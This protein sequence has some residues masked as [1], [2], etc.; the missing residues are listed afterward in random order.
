MYKLG[1]NFLCVITEQKV[2]KPSWNRKRLVYCEIG[3]IDKAKNNLNFKRLQSSKSAGS[4][5]NMKGIAYIL[6][7][8]AIMRRIGNKACFIG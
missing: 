7:K 2:T 5:H 4:V 6:G 8:K 1:K 3:F